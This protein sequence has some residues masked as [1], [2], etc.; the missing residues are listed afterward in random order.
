MSIT[1]VIEA[2]G[3]SDQKLKSKSTNKLLFIVRWN[4]S[5]RF[6]KGVFCVCV[7]LLPSRFNVTRDV[8]FSPDKFLM[9]VY[10]KSRLFRDGN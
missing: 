4:A 7:N 10:D 9:P 1:P 5:G 3:K 8:Q 2:S 6:P